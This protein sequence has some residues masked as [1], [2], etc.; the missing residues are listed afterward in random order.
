MRDVA[1][2]Q[3]RV[4]GAKRRGKASFGVQGM[5]EHI[6]QDDVGCCAQGKHLSVMQ[7]G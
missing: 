5:V 1:M 4:Q 2:K 3:R 7:A 6:R